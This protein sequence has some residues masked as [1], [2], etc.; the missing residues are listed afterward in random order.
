MAD[1]VTPSYPFRALIIDDSA[2]IRILVS[3]FLRH[4]GFQTIETA[5]NG[6]QGLEKIKTFN[7]DV[8]FLDG[9]MPEMDGMTVLRTVKQENPHIY[10][11]IASSLSEHQKILEF[12]QAGADYYLLKPFDQVKFE[13]MAKK[14]IAVLETRKK[15]TS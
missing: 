9:I 4:L 15:E 11:V 5:E 2:H 10:V 6:K 1:Q 14:V 7:P 8:I 12:K 3:K 13:E